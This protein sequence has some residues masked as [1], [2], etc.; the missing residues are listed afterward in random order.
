MVLTR[1][2]VKLPE[3]DLTNCSL[4]LVACS[5]PYSVGPRVRS[6]LRCRLS[7]CT[8]SGPYSVPHRPETIE[9]LFLQLPST[10][11]SARNK[12]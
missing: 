7:L 1:T 12:F 9:H 4:L 8:G 10:S 5:C 11:L 2:K 6:A 3:S